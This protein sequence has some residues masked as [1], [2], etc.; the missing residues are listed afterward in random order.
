MTSPFRG[1]PALSRGRPRRDVTSHCVSEWC[2]PVYC[3]R[4]SSVCR[5]E[6]P[7]LRLLSGGPPSTHS[8]LLSGFLRPR[9]LQAAS[10]HSTFITA[11]AGWLWRRGNPRLFPCP[12]PPPGSETRLRRLP[13]Y[14]RPG[15]FVSSSCGLNQAGGPIALATEEEEDSWQE[16]SS[17]QRRRRQE[18]KS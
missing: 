14:F 7:R 16:T 8:T 11:S 17:L 13:P 1:H 9:P 6:S 4:V 2:H 3:T 15:L 10:A 18:K 12:P 5:R